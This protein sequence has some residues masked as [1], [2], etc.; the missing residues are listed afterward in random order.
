MLSVTEQRG[1][2]FAVSAIPSPKPFVER[3]L[4]TAQAAHEIGMSKSWVEK[5][6][7]Y[8]FGPPFFQLKRPGS[9]AGAIRYRLSELHRWMQ[10]QQCNPGEARHG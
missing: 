7:V 2:G 5:G 3:F 1:R 6:R 9:K 8:G 4:N 10:D